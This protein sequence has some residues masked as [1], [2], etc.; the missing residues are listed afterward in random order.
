VDGRADAGDYKL[1]Y[2]METIPADVI[3]IDFEFILLRSDESIRAKDC[4]SIMRPLDFV[5]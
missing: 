5:V 4:F 1:F 2:E 3:K